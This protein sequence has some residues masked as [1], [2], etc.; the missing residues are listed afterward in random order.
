MNTE[1]NTN[2]NDQKGWSKVQQWLVNKLTDTEGALIPVDVEIAQK[3][4]RP[5]KDY[6]VVLENASKLMIRFKK[7]ERLIKMIVNIIDEQLGITH[8]AVLLYKEEKNAFILIDSRGENGTKIPAGFIRMT[9]ENPLIKIFNERKN[10]VISQNGVLAYENIKALL[11]NKESLARHKE[12]AG[13]IELVKRQMDL[14]K[15]NLCIP[16]YYKKNLIGILVLGDKTSKEQFTPQE[17]S[18]FMTLANNAAMAISNAQLIQDLQE[19]IDEIK[20]LYNREHSVFIHTAIALATAIDA[21]D[22]YTHGHTERVTTYCL[23]VAE[24]LEGIPEAQA[25][26]NFKETL[27]IAGLLHDVGKIGI[28]DSI[29]KKRGKLTKKEF[30]EI[31]GHPVIG[32]A[33]LAPIREL[34]DVAR[35]IKYHQEHYDGKGYPEG[36]KGNQIPL[37]ARII[38]TCDAF[39]AMTSDRPYRQ[40]KMVKTAIQEI[41]DCSGTQFDPLVVSAFLLAFE[42]GKLK[43][44]P[45]Q[46]K[47]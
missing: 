15:A 2:K 28:P 14:L 23:A 33:I 18:F 39:D 3:W 20:Y 9:L 30:E 25:Y 44:K 10:Y 17:I 29:L 1:F 35:E 16:L 42:K 45:R 13:L 47:R 46:V 19:R 38:A 7:P 6:Q 43:F 40:R 34:S 31:K 5:E 11:K 22:P 12:L 41:R 8:T 32:A 36:L 37:I 21:R 27:Q 4:P 26:K 24:E